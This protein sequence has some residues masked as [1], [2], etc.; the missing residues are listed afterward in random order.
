MQARKARFHVPVTL[1]FTVVSMV[2]AVAAWADDAGAPDA[3]PTFTAP[4]AGRVIPEDTSDCASP[5]K[6]G[7]VFSVAS[8]SC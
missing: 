4:D 5:P 7:V 3:G 6:S 1:T 8:C 2:H